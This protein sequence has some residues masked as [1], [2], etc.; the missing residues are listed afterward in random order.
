MIKLAYTDRMME[1]LAELRA[2]VTNRWAGPLL[3]PPPAPWPPRT[4]AANKLTTDIA[5]SGGLPGAGTKP[6]KPAGGSRQFHA[7]KKAPNLNEL[8]AGKPAAGRPGMTF[9]GDPGGPTKVVT[10]APVT[11]KQKFRNAVSKGAPSFMHGGKNIAAKMAPPSSPGKAVAKIAP[12][13]PDLPT[14][15]PKPKFQKVQG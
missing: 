6:G 7:F 9:R 8:G 5:T 1:K 2:K 13:S 10:G 3:G 4:S 15:Y 12:P 11:F 14:S